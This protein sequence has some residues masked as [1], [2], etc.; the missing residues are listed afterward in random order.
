MH[1][2]TRLTLDQNRFFYFSFCVFHTDELHRVVSVLTFTW[3]IE[4][5]RDDFA[6]HYCGSLYTIKSS[7]LRGVYRRLSRFYI[8]W[9][10]EVLENPLCT[11]MHHGDNIF[12]NHGLRSPLY[13]HLFNENF[14]G[15]VFHLLSSTFRRPAERI[16]SGAKS[17]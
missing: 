8:L 6:S 15:L 9:C 11:T 5:N 1:F 2:K 13:V 7:I 14:K 16:G 3:K 10:T 12:V 4:D 17:T